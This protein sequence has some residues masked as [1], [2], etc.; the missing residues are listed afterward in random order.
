MTNSRGRAPAPPK[1]LTAPTEPVGK[2]PGGGR[3]RPGAATSRHGAGPS[4]EAPQGVP[5]RR[6][7]ADSGAAPQPHGGPEPYAATETLAADTGLTSATSLAFCRASFWLA[8]SSISSSSCLDR[9]LELALPFRAA[10]APRASVSLLPPGRQGG[11]GV[12]APRWR[13]PCSSVERQSH[14]SSPVASGD[15][16]CAA[17]QGDSP[18]VP[19]LSAL[20]PRA[21]SHSGRKPHPDPAPELQPW[22][23]SR[24]LDSSKCKALLPSSCLAPPAGAAV[25]PGSQPLPRS[26]KGKGQGRTRACI[27]DSTARRN[28]HQEQVQQAT[29]QPLRSSTWTHWVSPPVPAVTVRRPSRCPSHLDIHLQGLALCSLLHRVP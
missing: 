20:S 13:R 25:T 6:P 3:Q 27:Q 22:G 28:G 26:C 19:C 12:R 4:A 21:S 23:P 1:R 11:P 8:A 18:Q 9:E 2:A 5:C 17:A 29:S 16:L 7:A 24:S 14:T 10:P 15:P